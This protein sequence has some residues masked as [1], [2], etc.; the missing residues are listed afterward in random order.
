MDNIIL[1]QNIRD[2]NIIRG[3][4]EELLQEKP[5]PESLK[6]YYEAIESTETPCRVFKRHCSGRFS[7]A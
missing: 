6:S 4:I 3:E 5:V 1:M 2:Y 7:L